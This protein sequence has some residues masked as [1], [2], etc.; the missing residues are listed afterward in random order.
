MAGPSVR[1][2]LN[3]KF[4]PA[5][6]ND[7]DFV[8]RTVELQRGGMPVFYIVFSETLSLTHISVPGNNTQDPPSLDGILS[9][10]PVELQTYDNEPHIETAIVDTS[11]NDVARQHVWLCCISDAVHISRFL[12]VALIYRQHLRYADPALDYKHIPDW[13]M[14]AGVHTVPSPELARCNCRNLFD[15][16]SFKSPSDGYDDLKDWKIIRGEMRND[17]YGVK[18][19]QRQKRRHE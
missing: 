18:E 8:Y 15:L 16:K 9:R 7:R 13:L 12:Y 11:F 4:T 10:P 17:R 5:F 3:G 1:K 14:D 2:T 6:I 19:M